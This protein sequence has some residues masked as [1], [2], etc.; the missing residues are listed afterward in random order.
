M[1]VDPPA[2]GWRLKAGTAWL[3]PNTE[4]VPCGAAPPAEKLKEGALPDPEAP[5]N[6]GAALLVLVPW[7][8]PNSEPPVPVGVDALP[9]PLPNW[10][11]EEVPDGAEPA[12]KE[13]VAPE[14]GAAEP[15]ALLPLLPEAKGL[16]NPP[17]GAVA[18]PVLAPPKLKLKPPV[19]EAVFD[20]APPKPTGPA[21]AVPPFCAGADDA[22]K[23][24]VEGA[25][26]WLPPKL[27]RGAESPSAPPLLK[28]FFFA[29]EGSSCF[30][31]LPNMLFAA[32]PAG[33]DLG[34][35][36]MGFD[37]VADG[38]KLKIGLGASAFA[39]VESVVGA[40]VAPNRG[41]CGCVVGVVAPLPNKLPAVLAG[42]E[43]KRDPA[44]PAAGAVADEAALPNRLAA[45]LGASPAEAFAGSLGL[46]PN[47]GDGAD[48]VGLP[49]C[50]NKL[51]AL[52]VVSAGLEA[53]GL[54]PK[55]LDAGLGASVVFGASVVA[56]LDW[57]IEVPK[58]EG[59][60]AG[61]LVSKKLFLAGC[62]SFSLSD[63]PPSLLVASVLAP[64]DD[65]LA[66]DASCF[67]A[68]K[69][70]DEA[71]PFGAK[72]ELP[73]AA[74]EL[75]NMDEAPAGVEAGANLMGVVEGFQVWSATAGFS[76][77]ASETDSDT[78]SDSGSGSGSDASIFSSMRTGWPSPP[79]VTRSNRLRPG[80]LSRVSGALDRPA[81]RPPAVKVGF[82]P[83]RL[84][85]T[86]DPVSPT[87][88]AATLGSSLWP[89]SWLSSW[90]DSDSL[91]ASAS[92]PLFL[93]ELASDRYPKM[94]PPAPPGA[95]G[96]PGGLRFVKTERAKLLLAA[97]LLAPKEL[98]LGA[99]A[100]GSPAGL[101]LLAIFSK[102]DLAEDGVDF[103]SLVGCSSLTDA[104]LLFLLTE[105]VD[106]V[107]TGAATGPDSSSNARR[108]PFR[109]G[110][111][112]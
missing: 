48:S 12:P 41:C 24:P 63:S 108:L 101:G 3:E 92:T 107:A 73:D 81:P 74:P 35:P 52:V 89:A 26:G 76:D 85:P 61:G 21:L 75:P 94:L 77:T 44:V 84:D 67:A 15:A 100:A 7:F 87:P 22:P 8:A 17:L 28:A 5:P 65:S 57:N 70:L 16:L 109:A 32:A 64:V 96:P 86:C 50:P 66:E 68:P 88:L 83:K 42:F 62:D 97:G 91:S 98:G 9:V 11:G 20:D 106:V 2:G 105:G 18:P 6:M 1:V 45:G 40:D 79:L 90:S 104:F 102:S 29:G 72:M 39:A 49:A 4:P 69:I 93:A 56:G 14:P 95:D 33:G 10:K 110:V 36:N 47:M 99:V 60:D 71:V 23:R 46:A 80:V 25:A 13:N 37:A 30:M 19:L 103:C 53:S 55:R 59:A 31:G 34:A 27:K 38:P 111:S 43:P 78:A 58:G 51:D 82:L 112:E 54:A